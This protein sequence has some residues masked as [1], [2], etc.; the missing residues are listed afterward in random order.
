MYTLADCYVFTSVHM[1]VSDPLVS[2]QVHYSQVVSLPLS[3]N[4]DVA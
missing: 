1:Y 3:V 4:T 2:F